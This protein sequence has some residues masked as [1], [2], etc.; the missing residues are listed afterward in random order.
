[1]IISISCPVTSFGLSHVQKYPSA[2]V[3]T[4]LHERHEAREAL[5][6]NAPRSV[7]YLILVRID[8]MLLLLTLRANKLTLSVPG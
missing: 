1:M 3:P 8:E 2:I 6:R 4:F 7:V 5:A